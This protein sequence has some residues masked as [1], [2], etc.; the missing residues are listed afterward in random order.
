VY[1]N[2]YGFRKIKSD[3]LRPQMRFMMKRQ[4]LEICHEKNFSKGRPWICWLETERV[5]M[6]SLDKEDVEFSH[7]STTSS[8]DSSNK[9]L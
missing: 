2:F 9:E 6:L 5:I 1:P 7:Y 3:P 8:Q 4:V